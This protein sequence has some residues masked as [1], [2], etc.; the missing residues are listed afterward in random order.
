M[1]KKF[2]YFA[3]YLFFNSILNFTF[4]KQIFI[5]LSIFLAFATT[6]QA[7]SVGIN[8]NTPDASAAL[9]VTS[10]TQGVLVPRMTAAQ[11]GLIS[12]PATGLL[13]YQTDGTAGFYF[14]NGTAWASLN[15]GTGGSSPTVQ[16]VVNA[17][18]A[19]S[20]GT[21]TGALFTVDYGTATTNVGGQYDASTNIFTVATTGFYHIRACLGWNSASGGVIGVYV[22]G[23]LKIIGAGASNGTGTQVSPFTRATGVA[24]NVLQLN[25]GDQVK[26]M[27]NTNTATTISVGSV[28][29]FTIV[30]L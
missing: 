18:D 14:Y 1:K 5:Y 16:L 29:D 23:S 3:K 8:T 9:D 21:G 15:G 24:A 25:A 6:V 22:N 10:T 20:Y 2:S 26:V 19:V 4:M 12:S 7:Q 30:K 11:R 13:V 17:V 27:F 28:S